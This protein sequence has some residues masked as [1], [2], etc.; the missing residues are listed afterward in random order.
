MRR[1]NLSDAVSMVELQNVRRFDDPDASS[2]LIRMFSAS[3]P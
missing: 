3:F 2:L 1:P